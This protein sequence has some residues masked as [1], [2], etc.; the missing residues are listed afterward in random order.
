MVVNGGYAKVIIT[1]EL[2]LTVSYGFIIT[3]EYDDGDR[4]TDIPRISM[5]RNHD[6]QHRSV[7]HYAR[8]GLC[9]TFAGKR[10]LYKAMKT[11]LCGMKLSFTANLVIDLCRHRNIM[12]DK[13][14][15]EL[16]DIDGDGYISHFE[17]NFYVGD[18]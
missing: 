11:K 17:K 12:L 18:N 14:V 5:K 8:H 6:T 16:F 13:W 15:A 2:F 7:H 10:Y 3:D 4:I 1:L 9:R